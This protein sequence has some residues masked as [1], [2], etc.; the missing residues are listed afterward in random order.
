MYARIVD[1]GRALAGVASSRLCPRVKAIDF[2]SGDQ[3]ISPISNRSSPAYGVIWR[4]FAAWEGSAT[5]ILLLPFALNSHATA[6]PVDAATMS[7][8][9]GACITSLSAYFA[10][11]APAACVM[12]RAEQAAATLQSRHFLVRSRRPPRLRFI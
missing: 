8:A 10:G 3:A 11:W 6:V 9:N 1:P 12:N 7:H 2:V 4:A 5:R